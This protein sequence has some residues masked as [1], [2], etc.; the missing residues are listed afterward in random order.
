LSLK[1]VQGAIAGHAFSAEIDLVNLSKPRIKGFTK[2]NVP[3]AL[4][5]RQLQESGITE[6]NG[7]AD[8]NVRF[9]T[10]GQGRPDAEGSVTL[11]SISFLA[12]IRKLPFSGW[13]G[14]LALENEVLTAKALSGKIGRSDLAIEGSLSHLLGY[15]GGT[16]PKLGLDINLQSK[17]IDLDEL[18]LVSTLA[19]QKIAAAAKAGADQNYRFEVA[20]GLQVSALCDINQLRFR[21]FSPRSIKGQI[22]IQRQ[23]IHFDNL[24]F[25]EVGGAFLLTGSLNARPEAMQ[26]DAAYNLENVRM[27]SLFYVME[28][29]NQQMLKSSQI[30]GR[31]SA[32]GN[33][34]LT[35]NHALE[36][37]APSV[38]AAAQINLSDGVLMYFE[39]AQALGSFIDKEEL[40]YLK[41]S[42]LENTLTIQNEVVTIPEM[43]IRSNLFR[44]YVRGTHTFKQD[45]DY[46]LK[47]PTKYIHRSSLD[48][49]GPELGG[50]LLLTL[51]GRA[52]NLKVGYDFVALKD[53]L[54]TDIQEEKQNFINLFKR[55]PKPT[56]GD[57]DKAKEESEKE[58][59][60]EEPAFLDL[61]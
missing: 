53:K 29:F 36:V 23:Q 56:S 33:V 5:T 13:Q 55:K 21:R 26:V 7:M 9:S 57:I 11:D 1:K 16:R 48:A 46:H 17:F 18:L 40:K 39:P 54:K 45:M 37:A 31:L 24:R 41:F 25:Q 30:Q 20:P 35:M 10:D 61:D 27:D 51:K 6:P 34:S 14:K 42:S 43:D 47:I 8:I 3:L 52:P 59:Q 58:A 19:P 28:D 4:F 50:N 15:L 2:A 60:K 22:D 38:V 44:C 12:G 49:G 32:K